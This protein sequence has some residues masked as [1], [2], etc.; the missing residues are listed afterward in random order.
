MKL[1]KGISTG[2]S[3]IY[4]LTLLLVRQDT[5]FLKIFRKKEK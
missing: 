3:I 4:K 5:A 2:L 1:L